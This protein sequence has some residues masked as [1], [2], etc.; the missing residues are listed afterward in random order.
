[1]GYVQDIA[2]DVTSTLVS[3]LLAYELTNS[4]IQEAV[5]ERAE[6]ERRSHAV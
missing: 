6:K 5:G 3:S 1:M 2:T 4:T